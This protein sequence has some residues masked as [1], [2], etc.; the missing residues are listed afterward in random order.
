[1]KKEIFPGVTVMFISVGSSLMTV[2][3]E[4]KK[5]V[6]VP[7]HSH[8][9]EQT[10]FI[11]SGCLLY[12]IDGEEIMLKEGEGIIVKPDLPHSCR[13]LEDTVDINTFFPPREDYLEIL[14]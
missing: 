6:V 5:G 7:E 8:R 3:F 10:S 4:L 12:S 1:M 13:A 2:R 11:Q 9:H 14:T